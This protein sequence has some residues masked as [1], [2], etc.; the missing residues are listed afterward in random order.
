MNNKEPKY[1]YHLF[2]WGGFYNEEY[3]KI[4]NK[5]SGNFWF[6]TSEERQKFIDELKEIEERLN[7]RYLMTSLSEGYCCGIETILH[8][9]VEWKGKRYYSNYNLGVNYPMSAA[10]YFLEWKWTCGFSDFPLGEDFDY[11]N[12]KPTV[13]QQWITGAVQEFDF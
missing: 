4:H 6:D 2:T 12:N 13:I 10:K 3:Q 1:E 5:S 9:V 11:E 8:R 7:A